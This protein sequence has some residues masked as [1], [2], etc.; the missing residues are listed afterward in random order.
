MLF[1]NRQKNVE[2]QLEKY[3]E[4]VHE[5]IRG[6]KRAMQT[7]CETNDA[8]QL[9]TDY[10]AVHRQESQADDIRRQIEYMMYSKTIFPESRGD[11]LGLLE[12]VDRVP[13]RA[14]QVIQ[15]MMTHHLRVPAAY[16]EAYIH[17]AG[18]V[19]RCTESLLVAMTYLFTDF[20][21]ATSAVGRVD[22][23]ESQSDNA[24]MSLI[25]RVFDS[26]LDPVQK[27]LLRDLV[28]ALGSVCD[29]A[30]NASDRIRIIVAKRKV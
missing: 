14:E 5:C 2:E 13:N 8:D 12:A 10:F 6:M 30:E 11:I 16:A 7:Y 24:E 18:L 15:M 19:V 4:K 27:I 17:I 25:G 26:D 9:R 1:V 23:L 3:R 28:V 20:V 21:E 29:R 22:E